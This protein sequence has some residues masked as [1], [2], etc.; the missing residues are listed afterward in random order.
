MAITA[1]ATSNTQIGPSQYADMT[2]VLTAR[3]KADGP[4]DLKPSLGTGRT[5]RVAAGAAFAAG[6]R[7][8][9]T[10]TEVVTHD[11]QSSGTRYD[12]VVIRIDWSNPTATVAIVKGTSTSIPVNTSSAADPTKINRI[13]GVLYD[14]LVCTV[15]ISAGSTTGSALTDY[16]MWGGDGG[17]LRVTGSA[18]DSPSLLDAR[19][20][21]FIATDQSTFTK[22]L[23]DDGVWRSV[24]TASNPWKEW[25]PHLRYYGNSAPNG[26][27]GGD[28]A[29]LGNG[30]TSSARYRIVDGML[31]GYVY[32]QP[33]AT[34]ATYGDGPMT[35]DMPVPCADWQADTWSM[36]H[37]YTFGYGGDGNFDWHAELLVKAGWTRGVVFSNP[38]AN[39]V[40]L[41]AMRAQ[42]PKGGAGTGI[43]FIQN[44]FTVGTLTFHVNYPVAD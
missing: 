28:L 42:R 34:G 13:P 8:R 23:D 16:R 3:F 35:I 12:A 36:G 15:R 19:L 6:T 21:T 25:T 4:N 2:Q 18:L 10:G 40:R 43:P 24:G 44:G 30:G 17:P 1:L 38:I 9:S 37:L 5:T 14:A 39:D 31:D 29:G 22:R 7:L 27:T 20:G 33:G 11:A 41:Q 32:I 26:T